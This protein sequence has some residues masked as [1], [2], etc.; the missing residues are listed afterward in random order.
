MHSKIS[1]TDAGK[2]AD[3]ATNGASSQLNLK[4]IQD[5][6]K[7]AVKSKIANMIGR[8]HKDSGD[9]LYTCHWCN[10]HRHKPTP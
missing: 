10:K 3:A 5:E 6:G 7:K 2:I 4:T 8:L 1:D 9:K